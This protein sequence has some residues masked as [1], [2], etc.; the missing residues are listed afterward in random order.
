MAR[1]YEKIQVQV[2]QQGSLKSDS[3]LKCSLGFTFT[4]QEDSPSKKNFLSQSCLV[5]AW[6]VCEEGICFSLATS[7][8]FASWFLSATQV[9]PG[10]PVKLFI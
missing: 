6:Q 2:P 1:K 9:S 4:F 10:I 3:V 5:K 7:M 8:V